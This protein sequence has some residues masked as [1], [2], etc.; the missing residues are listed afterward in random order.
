MVFVTMKINLEVFT[1]TLYFW[2]K[3]MF[4]LAI[5]YFPFIFQEWFSCVERTTIAISCSKSDRVFRLRFNYAPVQKVLDPN[6]ICL[7][8]QWCRGRGWRK[9]EW[10]KSELIISQGLLQGRKSSQ[11]SQCA[12][13]TTHETNASL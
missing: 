8:N 12:T 10:D 3:K 11:R 4:Y 6:T 5:V 9:N 2:C 1:Y 13:S 7:Y